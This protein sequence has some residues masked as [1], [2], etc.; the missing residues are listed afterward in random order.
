MTNLKKIFCYGFFLLS[1]LFSHAQKHPQPNIVIN[2]IALLSKDP[3]HKVC[4]KEITVTGAKTT[5]VYII[6]REIQFKKGD[7]L[8]VAQLNDELKKARQQVYNTTLFTEVQMQAFV[9]GTNDISITVNVKEKWYVYPVPQFQLVDRNF[10]VWAKTYNHSLSRVNYGLKFLDYNLTG[11]RDQLRIY[12]LGGYSRNIAFSYS[13]PYSNS[14]LTQGFTISAGFTQNREISYKSDSANI[15]QFYPVDSATKAR[16]EFVRNGWYVNAGYILRKGLFKRHIFTAAYTYLKVTDSIPLKY[17][18]NYFKDPVNAKGFFDLAYSYQYTNVDN[19]LY[20]LKGTV[21]FLS[22]LKRGL[23][24]T[25]GLNMF[26]IAGG[27]NKYYA[28]GKNWYTSFQLSGNIKLPFD[29]A[30]INQRGLG[31]GE[32]YLRGLEYNVVDGV[33]SALL[34]STLKKKIYSF[35]V[36][37]PVLHKLVTRIPFTIYAKTYAD[38]GYEYNKEKYYTYLNNRLLYTGGFGIDVLTLYDINFRFEYSFNQLGQSG[39]FFHTQNGF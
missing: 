1:A 22:V 6:L 39:L 10:N 24:F 31:Y 13:T 37:F 25:G 8:L 32:T 28:L 18:P 9:N 4:V 5:K 15:L 3:V 16:S 12:L 33:A 20:S 17:N 21:A 23:S 26:S 35:S 27:V 11:R 36:P 2:G 29:Q 30:Y 38:L 7:S 34:R 14:K 19:V